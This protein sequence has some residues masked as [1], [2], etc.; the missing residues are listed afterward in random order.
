MNNLTDENKANNTKIIKQYSADINLNTLKSL[1]S[2]SDIEKTIKEKTKVNEYNLI[3]EKAKYQYTR[4]KFI[5]TKN[6]L[7]KYSLLGLAVLATYG[8]IKYYY[9]IYY[10]IMW[11]IDIRK[12]KVS[13]YILERFR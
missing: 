7:K 6:K 2:S 11:D 4:I 1:L 5:Q 10:Y 8:T 12:P 3:L 13:D 9:V